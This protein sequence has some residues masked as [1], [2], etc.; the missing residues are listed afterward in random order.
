MSALASRSGKYVSPRPGAGARGQARA[1]GP[2]G[3][4]FVKTTKKRHKAPGVQRVICTCPYHPGT[5]GNLPV[6]HGP[7][8][9]AL[10]GRG[11]PAP[12]RIRAMRR[13]VIELPD[14]EPA[15]TVH[16]RIYGDVLGGIRADDPPNVLAEARR[17]RAWEPTSKT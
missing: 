10:R 13:C 5:A 15:A 2:G 12:Q 8:S 6:A 16:A 7:F 14:F 3:A 9:V 1:G 11:L 17:M 4:F